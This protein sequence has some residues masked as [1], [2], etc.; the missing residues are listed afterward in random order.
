VAR[1]RLTTQRLGYI[2]KKKRLLPL[3]ASFVAFFV[4]G[5][6]VNTLV[7]FSKAYDG[8]QHCYFHSGANHVSSF[9]SILDTSNML[10]VTDPNRKQG[11]LTK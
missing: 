2:F 4:I 1:A 9:W 11:F 3:P 6:F 7:R 8:T 5:Q 10:Q